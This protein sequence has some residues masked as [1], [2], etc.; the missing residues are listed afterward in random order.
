[1]EHIREAEL[2]FPAHRQFVNASACAPYRRQGVIHLATKE[3]AIYV[4]FAVGDDGQVFF[5][6]HSGE[7][8]HTAW[9]YRLQ[10]NTGRVAVL[11]DRGATII[12]VAH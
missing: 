8:F 3:P 6:G 12:V 5:G 11:P 4:Y 10:D 2:A 7:G 9:R 1:M